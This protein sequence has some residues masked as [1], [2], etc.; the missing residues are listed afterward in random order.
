MNNQTNHIEK[1][2]SEIE[3][4]KTLIVTGI[5]GA[6]L[7]FLYSSVIEFGIVLGLVIGALFGIAIGIRIIRNPP[8][9]RYPMYLLRRTL[10]AAAF[11]FLT[12]YVYDNLTNQELSQMQAFLVT[13]LPWSGWTALVVSM[14]MM[15]AHL[16]ELQR[17]IQ[18]EA[19]AIGFAGTA[20]IVGGYA[21]LQFVGFAQINI[22][23][24]ILIMS[25]M[26]L[27]GKLWTLWRYR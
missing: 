18:T 1:R 15:I 10:L 7:G 16:D 4:R 19:I 24:V 9:M 6:A 17:R 5:T 23:I 12:T 27:I 26:W 13:L 21:L 3:D 14:G 11:L 8:K 22:G 20:I 25:L 2:D